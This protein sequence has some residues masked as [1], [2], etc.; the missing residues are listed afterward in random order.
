MRADHVVRLR[1]LHP[2]LLDG[3]AELLVD[4]AQPAVE[5]L[6]AHLAHDHV[7]ARLGSHLRD[8]VPHQAAA[9]NANLLDVHVAS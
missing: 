5:L 8:A 1:L 4:L 3:P 7:V 9:D 6:L 2:A